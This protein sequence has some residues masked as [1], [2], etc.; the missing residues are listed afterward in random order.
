MTDTNPGLRHQPPEEIAHRVDRFHAV[1][2]EIHLTAAFH[3]V[4]DGAPHD[5]LVELHDVGLDRQP[6]LRRRFDDRHIADAGERH[7]ER[8]RNRGRRHRED[9]DALLELFDFFF[10]R[11]AEAL[12]LVDDEETEVSELH[13][14]RQQPVR[15]YDNFDFARGEVVERG[16]LLRLRAE[17]ADHVDPDRERSEPIVQRLQVLKCEHRRR[18][19]QRHLLAVHHG[20]E[21]RAHGNLGLAVAHVAAQQTIHRRGRLHVAFDVANRI[22]L[23]DRQLPLERVLEFLLP[24][25]VWTERVARN[26]LARRIELQQLFGHVAHRLLDARL[27]LFPRCPAQF[28]ERRP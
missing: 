28:V 27:G 13:V 12:L 9:V 22:L 4:S 19:Q 15:A 23:I 18:G 21:G 8:P 20:L 24:V 11:D 5:F 17:A 16:L 6:I 7:V 2:D 3:L 26:R 25:A 10:V 1:V 14:F